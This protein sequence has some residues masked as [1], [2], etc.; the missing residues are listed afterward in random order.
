MPVS[1]P[2]RIFYV[3][4]F[5]TKAKNNITFYVLFCMSV[6]LHILS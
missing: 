3:L 2:L 6:N 1:V 4:A 5:H